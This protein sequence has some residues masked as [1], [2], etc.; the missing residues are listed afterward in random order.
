MAIF[1][2]VTGSEAERIKKNLT[3]Q[4]QSLWLRLTIDVNLKI[5][6]FLDLTLS[7]KSGK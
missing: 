2:G 6:N 4:F 7:L 5:V 1:K 3:K